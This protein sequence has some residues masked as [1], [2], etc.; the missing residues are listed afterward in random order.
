MRR[1]ALLLVYLLALASVVIALSGDASA[2]PASSS[3]VAGAEE[4]WAYTI[5][6]HATSAVGINDAGDIIA[7]AEPHA[8]LWRDGRRTDLGTLGGYRSLASDINNRGQVVG[9]SNTVGGAWHAFLWENG[10]MMDLGPVS[11][12]GSTGATAINGRGQVIGEIRDLGHAFI[13][14]NGR[15]R[16]LGTLGGHAHAVGINERGQVAGTSDLKRRDPRGYIVTHAFLWENGRMHDL[17]TLGGQSS[18]AWAIDNRG[19]IVGASQTGA[20]SGGVPIVH[21]FAWRDG[22]MSDLGALGGKRGWGES[23][24]LGINSRGEIVGFSWSKMAEEYR[25]LL[26]ENGR[27]RDIASL[28]AVFFQ[29][30]IR[31]TDRGQVVGAKEH[32]P[33]VWRE[34][35]RIWLQIR[36]RWM[37]IVRGISERDQIVGECWI[38]GR[39]LETRAV[40]WT[41]KR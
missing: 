30:S 22:K 34:G 24:A 23:R 7:A 19:E 25:L 8:L 14:E 16:D 33:Y 29:E 32:A 9:R 28:G 15:M 36:P 6:P 27:M 31:I 17:G 21:A 1:I 4:R 41:L 39:A 3:V 5:L 13:W 40:L 38:D 2:R 35:R 10:R 20:T 11:G 12:H 18:E 26:W 37:C